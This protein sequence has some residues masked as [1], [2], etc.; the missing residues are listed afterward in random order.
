MN[1]PGH[2]NYF[3]A[4]T[5]KGLFRQKSLNEQVAKVRVRSY[6]IP[7]IHGLYQRVTKR[8]GSV[9]VRASKEVSSVKCE[10]SSGD[11]ALHTSNFRRDTSKATPHGVTTSRG[12]TSGQPWLKKALVSIYYWSG[13]PFGLGDKLEALVEKRTGRAN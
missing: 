3:T 8:A 13:T 10:V 12:G 2:C 7:E 9:P 1:P 11:P 5:L 4:G 6:G